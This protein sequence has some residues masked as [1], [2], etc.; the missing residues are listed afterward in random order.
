MGL[1]MHNWLQRVAFWVRMGFRTACRERREEANWSVGAILVGFFVGTVFFGGVGIAANGV[2]VGISMTAVVAVMFLI[3]GN[4]IGLEQD[5][6][7]R[8]RKVKGSLKPLA[9]SL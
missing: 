3:V 8:L 1:K 7:V 9:A 6:K 4:R 2:G 5:R